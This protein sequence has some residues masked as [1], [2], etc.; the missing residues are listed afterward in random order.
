MGQGGVN[1]SRAKWTGCFPYALE[2]ILGKARFTRHS[3]RQRIERW[4]QGNVRGDVESR[5]QIIEQKWR[6]T[7]CVQDNVRLLD[8]TGNCVLMSAKIW[9][10][11]D[12]TRTRPHCTYTL[13][14]GD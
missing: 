14:R 4:S 13:I 12:S 5:V 8:M 6:D 9:P 3:R 1:A 10:P 2:R 11:F 7:A